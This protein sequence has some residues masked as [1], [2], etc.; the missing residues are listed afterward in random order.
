MRIVLSAVLLSACQAGTIVLDDPQWQTPEPTGAD[1]GA[2]TGERADPGGHVAIEADSAALEGIRAGESASTPLTIHNDGDGPLAL[3]SIELEG[4]EF[5]LEGSLPASL[6]AGESAALTLRYTPADAG[7]DYANVIIISDDPDTP[8][9]VAAIRGSGIVQ[10][11][12]E[13]ILTV[14][15]SLTLAING[16]AVETSSGD[17]W[18]QLDR[19]SAELWPGEALILALH[20]QN[21]GTYGALIAG[22]LVDGEPVSLSGDGD[23]E[24]TLSAPADGWQ[25]GAGAQGWE[26]AAVCQTTGQWGTYYASELLDEGA[27]WVGPDAGCASWSEAW[28]RLSL[29][30]E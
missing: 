7:T 11:A 6:A 12:V 2:D 15:N 19:I 21:Q 4:A 9:F 1:T 8:Q 27:V 26:A 10:R 23:W 18:Q 24:V 28:F 5:S 20:A 16:E 30:V 22:V 13:V 29:T 25:E 3:E 14:D 17:N